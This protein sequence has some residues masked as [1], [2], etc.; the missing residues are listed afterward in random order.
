ML[1]HPANLS[2]FSSLLSQHNF[3]LVDFFATWCGPCK[4]VAPEFEALS[5]Q[6]PGIAFAKVDVDAN[7]ETAQTYQV[8]AMPTFVFFNAGAEIGRIKGANMVHLKTILAAA[9]SAATADP[10]EAAASSASGQGNQRTCHSSAL[11]VYIYFYFL[12]AH[13]LL[14]LSD[15]HL[16]SGQTN[17][18]C[19]KGRD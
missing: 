4:A 7:Q 14:Q 11:V 18:A 12:F 3:V 8:S 5:N 15:V 17:R 9:V 2:E 19:F 6:Y 10:S 1:H 13:F 16:G